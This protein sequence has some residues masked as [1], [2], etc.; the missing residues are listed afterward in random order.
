MALG[1][2]ISSSHIHSFKNPPLLK[3][4]H[5]KLL[6][7][8][9]PFFQTLASQPQILFPPNHSHLSLDPSLSKPSNSYIQKPQGTPRPSLY[10][11]SLYSSSP[12][13]L[14]TYTF[15]F[16]LPKPT[17]LSLFS[18]KTPPLIAEDLLLVYGKDSLKSRMQIAMKSFPMASQKSSTEITINYF[19]SLF[20]IAT[21]F[22]FFFIM[23]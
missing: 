2:P 9:L 19:D 21:S 6:P 15:L 7:S 14:A 10:N 5:Q 22:I 4:S 3:P 13:I 16:S 23:Q 20:S 18:T 17:S 8:H 11:F 12:K 1:S